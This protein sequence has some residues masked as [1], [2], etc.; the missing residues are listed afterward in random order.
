M[1]AEIKCPNCGQSYELADELVSQYA[2]QAITCTN[3]QKPFT[4]P[5]DLRAAPPPVGAPVGYAAPPFGGQQQY[6]P[7]RT[8]G[9][10]IASVVL[11]ACGFL[12]PIF[13]SI[14]AIILGIIGLRRT[15]DPAV[16][17]KGMAITGIALGGSSVLAGI[18]VWGCLLSILLPSLNR[19]RETA[20][21]VKC[22]ANMKS[23]GQALLLYA[24]D[25]RGAYPARIEDLIIATQ[26]VPEVF[27]CPSSN[28]TTASG[29]TPQAVAQNVTAGGHLSYVY[30]GQ[31]F[32]SSA[33]AETVILYE[34]LSDH[35]GGSNF[36]LGDGHVDFF[37]KS[38]AERFI[39]Q[40]QAGVNPPR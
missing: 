32:G 6:A 4:V 27:A 38:E 5:A 8:N 19:A 34:P 31:K 1:P 12:I 39:K 14:P 9:M 22:A 24:S 3:C 2:G 36:L 29:A 20:N 30:V 15:R 18:V 21:R 28:D 35:L 10:A 17:G 16:G 25:N 26:L 7:Q 13:A 11:G 33:G 23:I 37:T 40:L